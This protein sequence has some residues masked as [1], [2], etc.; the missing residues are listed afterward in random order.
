MTS[1]GR[2]CRWA[3]SLAPDAV[4]LLLVAVAT[5]LGGLFALPGLLQVWSYPGRPRPFVDAAGKPLPRSNS[6]KI[7]GTINGVQQGMLIKSKTQGL[8]YSSL[9]DRCWRSS[10]VH[11]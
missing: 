10:R 7:F 11:R 5:L 9:S 8:P 6:E 2:G 4:G 3:R 1:G